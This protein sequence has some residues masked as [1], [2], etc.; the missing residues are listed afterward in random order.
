MKKYILA[1]LVFGSMGTTLFSQSKLSLKK[2]N[3]LYEMRS[4]AAAI[5][6]FEAE[7]RNAENLE[8]LGDCYYYTGQVKKAASTYGELNDT[9]V[10]EPD[11]D[12]LFR[13]GQALKGIE[14][15]DEADKI[16]AA[17]FGKN[18]NSFAFME[19]VRK[20]TPHVFE[21]SPLN[22]ANGKEDFGLSFFGKDR[23][24]FAS[25]RNTDNPIYLWNNAPYL[26]LYNGIIN[27]Q[28][29]L[30]DVVP[31]PK[32][33][34]T[35]SHES[36]ATF[37]HDG[38]K[39]YFNRTNKKRLKEG[40]VKVANI[41]IYQADLVEGVWTNVRPL[42]FTSD[43]YNTEHPTL[44]KDGSMLYFASDMPGSLGSFD[45]YKV[46]IMEDGITG[47]P[48]NLGPLV[49]TEQREQFPF[50]SDNNTLYFS[51]DGHQG[52]GGLDVFRSSHVNGTF[53]NPINLGAPLNSPLDDFNYVVKENAATG[54]VSSNRSGEDKIYT[55]KRED[56][57]LTKYLVT[58][59]V[60]DKN[61]LALLPGSL[62]TLFDENK[63]VLQ[64][65]IVKEDA[66]Y[67]FKIEPNKKYTVRGTRKLYIP[68]DV[69]FSTDKRG[70]II[71]NILLNLESYKD[72]EDRITENTR[73]DVQVNLERI[74]FDFNKWNI[75]EDA[76]VILG[77]LV[78]IMKKYP[79]MEIEVASHTD[80]RGSNDYNLS[81]SKK[82]AA[83]T[84]EFLVSQGID[85]N[86]LRSIGYGEE[87]PLNRCVREGIC[88]D[89]EYDINRRSEFTILK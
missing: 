55:L 88:T 20:T 78:G 80:A 44:S 3:Q 85:R 74:Y 62:V 45:I 46:P 56:N 40:D 61:S 30:T 42:A 49:N 21:V 66:T 64:D 19:E 33:I 86:R 43:S 60:Q 39:M 51:S 24:A 22:N 67:L 68:F 72:A 82:R 28:N 15:Y 1:A 9:Y 2:T 81:L 34:N 47:V 25:A 10:V 31:F 38:T 4:Y 18:H 32:E 48:V 75:R 73:G 53:A 79:E 37:N 8:K 77:T 54:F 29:E 23:V 71:H 84:L 58:G 63:K 11:D 7:E 59:I 17:Y 13:Y 57:F 65:T 87:Q 50:I 70:K 27:E 5:E 26:D 89:D 36:N 76:A 16:L 14:K 35:N 12:V 52:F 69:D 6:G 41:K 83:S